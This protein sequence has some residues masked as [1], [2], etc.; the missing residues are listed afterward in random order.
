MRAL[1]RLLREPVVLQR[2]SDGAGTSVVLGTLH[3]NVDDVRSLL[4]ELEDAK[5]PRGDAPLFASVR[6]RTAGGREYGPDELHQ[7]TN[8]QW[9]GATVVCRAPDN[10]ENMWRV[11]V[12]FSPRTRTYV[13]ADTAEEEVV[14]EAIERL[15]AAHSMHPISPRGRARL[16]VTLGCALGALA[17]LLTVITA[18]TSVALSVFLAALG[19]GV[20]WSVSRRALDAL[21]VTKFQAG[22]KVLELPPGYVQVVATSQATMDQRRHDARR[23]RKV[24]FWTVVV[25]VP[26]GGVGT[27]LLTAWLGTPS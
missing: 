22:P 14:I 2:F 13:T 21:P 7:L 9:D 27:W 4:V 25:S 26:L 19:L 11:G 5:T 23:D 20:A 12:S 24:I 10:D 3:L 15:W 16:W 17:W 18:D 1:D 8:T 6:V